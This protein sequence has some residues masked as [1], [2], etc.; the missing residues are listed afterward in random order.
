M[1]CAEFE[2]LILELVRDPSL[3]GGQR[4][5]AAAHAQVCT[6]CGDRLAGELALTAGLRA[7]A[8]SAQAEQAPWTVEAALRRAF[9]PVE[10]PAPVR[11]LA[12]RL[13]AA[14][15][16]GALLALS[17]GYRLTHPPTV[18]EPPAAASAP[19][20]SQPYAPF[21]PLL[22]GDD[23]STM[24]AGG[25]VRV[26]LTRAALASFGVPVSEE[27]RTERVEAEVLLGEDGLARAIRLVRDQY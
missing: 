9:V 6:R 8:A 19:A 27:R 22:Y 17:V 15:A 1:K 25:V 2:G 4:E 18:S 16:A 20:A 21:Y 11:R 14:V 26:R 13:P 23:L 10:A 5:Q 24:E 12:W 7:L 3:P